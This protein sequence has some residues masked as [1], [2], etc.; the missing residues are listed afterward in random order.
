MGQVVNCEVY[1]NELMLPMQRRL[2]LSAANH[3]FS[4]ILLQLMLLSIIDALQH[5]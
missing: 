3:F 5:G 4:L 1:L 2:R